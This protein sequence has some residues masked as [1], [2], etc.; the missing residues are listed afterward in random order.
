MYRMNEIENNRI[1][2]FILCIVVFIVV[3]LVYPS[4]ST[5][6]WGYYELSES[7]SNGNYKTNIIRQY[8]IDSDRSVSF[9]FLY[10]GILSIF[11]FLD[12]GIYTGVIVN[13]I[14]LFS[15]LYLI[16]CYFGGAKY[17]GVLTLILIVNYD[18][19][20]EIISGRSI[21][22]SLFLTICVYITLTRSKYN[23]ALFF[24][25]LLCL[26]RF[27]AYPFVFLLGLVFLFYCG[28]VRFFGYIPFLV[29]SSIWPIYSFSFFN[30][31]FITE[32]SM[33]FSQNLPITDVL[34]YNA[35][36]FNSIYEMLSTI[37]NRL[38]WGVAFSSIV[39]LALYRFRRGGDGELLSILFCVCLYISV[40]FVLMTGY[41]DP[42]YLS[43]FSLFIVF[44]Y[45]KYHV[46]LE[47]TSSI[48]RWALCLSSL[49]LLLLSTAR[50][51]VNYVTPKEDVIKLIG[52]CISSDDTLLIV[53]D[54]INISRVLSTELSVVSGSKT[55]MQ[56]TNLS[57]GNV[58]ELIDMYNVTH[59]FF[60]DYSGSIEAN[61]IGFVETRCELLYKNVRN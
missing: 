42:R 3:G 57:D 11:S 47:V 13:S 54:N 40:I 33:V 1:V 31:A 60:I 7:L 28:Y 50:G 5:D 56:P 12:I 44:H 22:L 10:P 24:M 25:G 26:N 55:V 61:P 48:S 30:E 4:F 19:L 23:T 46:S 21:P 20:Y 49:F 59:L 8:S 29:L 32:N 16:H 39:V 2:V 35:P 14:I 52:E 36:G 18:F 27:D 43:I 51:Y 9:P 34:Y 38:G 41:K 45:F 15:S 53:S 6:S 17:F 37:F 58:N